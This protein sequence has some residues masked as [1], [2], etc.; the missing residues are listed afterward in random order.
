VVTSGWEIGRFFKFGHKL[1]GAVRGKATAMVTAYQLPGHGTPLNQEI[2]SVGTYITQAKEV[3]FTIGAQQ[4]GL[5]EKSVQQLEIHCPFPLNRCVIR[6]YK[7]PAL[8]EYL[9]PEQIEY[10]GIAVE[11]SG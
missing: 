5:S 3:I 9:L 8:P 1:K 4:Q 11:G 7:L 2:P 10:P 6:M